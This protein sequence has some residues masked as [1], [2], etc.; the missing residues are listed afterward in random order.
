MRDKPYKLL[1]LASTICVNSSHTSK[2]CTFTS[3]TA[4]I[5]FMNDIKSFI[6]R[7][8]EELKMATKKATTKTTTTKKTTASASKAV[9]KKTVIQFNGCEFEFDQEATTKKVEAAFKKTYK[10][11]E[12]VDLKMYVKPEEGKV[13]YVANTDCVGSVDL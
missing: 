12:L 1:W 4:I 6:N 13:Y 11:K 5:C 3:K 9:T 8:G 10:G 7:L 2:L